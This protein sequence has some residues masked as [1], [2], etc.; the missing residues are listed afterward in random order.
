MQRWRTNEFDKY[1]PDSLL[2]VIIEPNK[3]GST[4]TLI[5]VNIPKGQTK[6]Y[7]QGWI[8]Y[9]FERMKQYFTKQL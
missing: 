7:K 6:K 2:T 1:D 3:K 9:Y 5:Q 4:L 8:E